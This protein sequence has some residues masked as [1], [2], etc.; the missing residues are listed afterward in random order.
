ML[1]LTNEYIGQYGFLSDAVYPTNAKSS[2]PQFLDV[3]HDLETSQL[4]YKAQ[5]L[6]A[7]SVYPTL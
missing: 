7:W 6:Q 4:L 1:H 3:S 5:M 2:W